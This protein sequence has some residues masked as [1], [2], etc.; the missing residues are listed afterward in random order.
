MLTNAVRY[1]ER[2]G[3]PVVDVLD[4]VR[5]L[6]PLDRRHL[7][8][9]NAEGRLKDGD[10]MALVAGE[11]ADLAGA[12]PREAQRLL[13]RTVELGWG[14]RIDPRAD[15]G[16]GEVFVPELEILLPEHRAAAGPR[17]VAAEHAAAQA[18][19]VQRCE[20]GLNGRGYGGADPA[21]RAAAQ[22]L[23][24]ELRTIAELGF[25]GYFLTVAEVVDLIR[26]MG[27]RVAARGSGAGSL[28]NHVLGISGVDPMRHGLLME[29]FLSPLRRVL[30]DIDI[31]V[32]SARRTE[33]YERILERFGGQRCACVSMMETYRVRH[34]VRDVGA[35]LGLPPGE[36]DAFAKAFP[37]IRARDARAALR[38][39]PELRSSSLGRQ[40]ARGELDHYLALVESLD[41]LPRHIA[42][43]PCGVLLSD[44]T[45]LDRTPVES[46][47]L[48]FP[49]SQ[50]DKDDV[51]ELGLLKLDVLGIR[52]QSAMAHAVAEVERVDGERI[53]LDAVALDDRPTY[54][55]IASTR[56]LGCFQIESPGQRELIGKF[57][58]EDFDDII[59]DISLFRPGPVKSDMVTPFLNARHGWARAAVPAPGSAGGAAVHRGGRGVPRAG[60]AD[61]LD[62]HRLLPGAGRRDPA[63]PGLVRGAAAGPGLVLLSRRCAGLRPR[64][65]GADLGRADG[66]R[67]LRLLQGARRGLRAAHLPVGVAEDAP[68]GGVPGRG[69]HP[70]PGH[71]PQAAHPRRRP[72]LRGGGAAHR[73]RTPPAM[74]T[75]WRRG[76]DGYGIRLPFGE[77]KGISEAEVA[78]ITAGQPYAGLADF[79]T[80]SGVSRPVAEN[81]V[82]VGA[83]DALYGIGRDALRGAPQPRH[84]ARPAAVGGRAGPVQ[85]FAVVRTGEGPAGP[86]Q[87]RSA[88]RRSRR[89]RRAAVAGV[90]GSVLRPGGPAAAR[91]GRRAGRAL[92]SGLPEMDSG[93]RVRAELEVLG[94]D[95]SMHVMDF[96]RPMLAELGAVRA[97][98]LVGCRSKEQVLVAGMKVATQTPPVR[99]GR[100][101]VFLTV[102]DGSGPADATFF[103][104]AQDP[105]ADTVFHNWLLLVRGQVRRTGRRGVS[106]RATGAW[107]LHQIHRVW[108][109]AGRRRGDRAARAAGRVP[110]PRRRAGPAA[111][112]RRMLVHSSGFATNVYADVRPAGRRCRAARRASCGTP[113][114]A[115]ADGDADEQRAVE[116]G[117][118]AH[119]A[120]DRRHRLHHPARRHG[121]LLRL[122]LPAAAPRSWWAIRWWWAARA[123]AGWCCRPPTRP[124]RSACIRRC[125]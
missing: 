3:A 13:E 115:A 63:R 62:H 19:L 113:A 119:R 86:L 122:R 1:V 75:G 103:E 71:V 10:E 47:W 94:L 39:L 32:E 99:S 106:I 54:D 116:A 43:H 104:D 27:V 84:P 101:V 110:H 85:P 102:D 31:D 5:R 44:S 21:S 55:L 18:V 11:I 28:V 114:P 4:A 35:A 48:G 56:T 61:H 95:V 96:Y 120:G 51:E 20:A 91:S 81:L 6:V 124:G 73:R 9:D 46:S 87:H 83:F 98:E 45:L 92:C 74:S 34:A 67:L 108:R 72:P 49:M 2:S 53:D 100:R 38:D 52:M 109:R 58:P 29:R 89:Q 60:H 30:P 105:Y 117:D 107:D 33:I 78:R 68:S 14:C 22:R 123:T 50:F 57:G 121:R 23:D 97:V 88:G 16:M 93:E 64:R 24:E 59:I 41:G 69:A 65:G 40:A 42:L 79:V 37:H 77:V 111:P 82:V 76:A 26:A 90:G 17:D 7:D 8:R 25:A 118:R 15:L 36:M 80:R 66:V 112:R 12:G 70:R 125:P